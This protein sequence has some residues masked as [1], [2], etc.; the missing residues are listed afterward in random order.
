MVRQSHYNA[1][2]SKLSPINKIKYKSC[3]KAKSKELFD[4]C[5]KT[6][7]YRKMDSQEELRNNFLHVP[8]FSIYLLK[9]TI[10]VLLVGLE[11]SRRLLI[12]RKYLFC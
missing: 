1:D 7:D 6:F 5:F 4:N 12:R 2:I 9:F 8:D 3:Y 10:T 11:I